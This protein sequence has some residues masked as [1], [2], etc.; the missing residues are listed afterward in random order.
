MPLQ[1]VRD[2]D[3][4]Q[5]S[6]GHT[7][8]DCCKH[9]QVVLFFSS[10]GNFPNMDQATS[11]LIAGN[12]CFSV[13]NHI[14]AVAEYT[15]GI[16]IL[17]TPSPPPP[18]TTDATHATDATTSDQPPTTATNNE[19]QAKTNQ[20][21]LLSVLHSNRSAASLL[22][23]NGSQAL[24]DANTALALDPLRCKFYGRKGA[25]LHILGKYQEAVLAYQQGLSVADG[26]EHIGLNE[27]IK[28]VHLTMSMMPNSGMTGHKRPRSPSTDDIVAA[29]ASSS[30]VSSTGTTA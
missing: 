18:P 15:S 20:Q 12:A 25:A 13:R 10:C 27:G 17:T 26:S 1:I 8:E 24:N 11:S 30:S 9:D 16:D 6:P 28:A 14:G 21:I 7:E 19:A 2:L 4:H 22:L 23:A 3:H 29:E 5:T